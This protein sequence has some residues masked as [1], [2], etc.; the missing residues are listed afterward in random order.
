MISLTT[1]GCSKLDDREVLESQRTELINEIVS[2]ESSMK[3]L[4]KKADLLDREAV[5][6]W[7]A[8][9]GQTK[10]FE[11][12]LKAIERKLGA[13]TSI[14]HLTDEERTA[15]E[16]GIAETAAHVVR[17]KQKMANALPEEKSD[18]QL[19]ILYGEKRIEFW[20]RKLDAEAR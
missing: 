18:L 20:Q 14:S 17:L 6:R 9:A 2:A 15:F 19:G 13:N 5:M 7:I 3:E 1:L 4:Q 11:E 16:S 12:E 8:L 10:K